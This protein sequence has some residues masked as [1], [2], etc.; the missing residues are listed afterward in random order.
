M[1]FLQ[2]TSSV[3]QSTSGWNSI[4]L[5]YRDCILPQFSIVVTMAMLF[6]APLYRSRLQK[7]LESD[8][9]SA[10]LCNFTIA[11]Y[12]CSSVSSVN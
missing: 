3:L 8:T 2:R 9:T 11:E 5:L 4:L 12:A 7:T 1:L 6:V 10:V